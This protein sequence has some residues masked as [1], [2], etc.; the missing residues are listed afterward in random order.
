MRIYLIDNQ[1]TQS[2]DRLSIHRAGGKTPVPPGRGGL[3]YAQGPHVT[4]V[5]NFLGACRR[6]LLF[7]KVMS[8]KGRQKIESQL[9]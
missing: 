8:K 4:Y 2:A 6:R 3:T 7:C 5:K 1:L 9:L